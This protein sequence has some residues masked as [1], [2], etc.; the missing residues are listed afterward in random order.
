M[1]FFADHGIGFP[2]PYTTAQVDD[3]RPFLNGYSILNLAAPLHTVIA[4]APLFLK[5]PAGVKVA[6]VTI[7]RF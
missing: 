5:P 2:S 6:I 1:S 3:C 4:L 7:I